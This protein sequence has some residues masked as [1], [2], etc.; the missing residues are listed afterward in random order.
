MANVALREK[1]CAAWLE[2]LQDGGWLARDP[3]RAC[4]SASVHADC[5]ENLFAHTPHVARLCDAAYH[6]MD[7]IFS[8]CGACDCD[9]LFA[10]ALMHDV[11]KLIEFDFQ[12]GENRFRAVHLYKHPAISAYYAKNTACPTPSFTPC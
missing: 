5:P 9:A 8:F 7:P 2:A 6:G 11:G 3:M 1:I 10:C 4:I 12:N